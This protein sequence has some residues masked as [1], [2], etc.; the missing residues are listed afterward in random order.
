[1]SLFAVSDVMMSERGASDRLQTGLCQKMEWR[2]KSPSACESGGAAGVYL[3][4][5]DLLEA[6][7]ASGNFRW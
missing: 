4:S 1:M 3:N 2:T 6:A 7:V 5:L